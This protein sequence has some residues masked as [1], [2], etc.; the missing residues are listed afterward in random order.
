VAQAT[1]PSQVPPPIGVEIAF[2]GRSNVGKSSLLNSLLDRKGLART[3]STPGCTRGLTFFDVRLRDQ[4]RVTFVDLPG[5]GYAQR[6][7]QERRAWAELIETYLLERATLAGVVILVDARRGVEEEEHDL[8]KLLETPGRRSTWRRQPLLVATKL[9]KLKSSQ[10]AAALQA[11][12]RST[13][14]A[15][16]GYSTEG[17]VGRDEV[18][19]VLRTLVALPVTETSAT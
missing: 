6:S 15:V 3:S 9:D 17:H 16:I 10:R 1:A 7:K 12:R 19:T 13:N 8:L 11:I 5:Y 14:V 2:A 4:A 18:W